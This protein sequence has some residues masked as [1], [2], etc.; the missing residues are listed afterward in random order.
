MDEKVTIYPK[1]KLNPNS[2]LA[3]SFLVFHLGSLSNAYT[4][5]ED[6]PILLTTSINQAV[7]SNIPNTP[8]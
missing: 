7:F 8:L 1:K 4:S 2:F 6:A 3:S 5:P